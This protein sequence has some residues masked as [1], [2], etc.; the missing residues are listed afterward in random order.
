MSSPSNS[1]IFYVRDTSVSGTWILFAIAVG[2]I[3][4]SLFV[5]EIMRRRDAMKRIFYPR[6]KA[7]A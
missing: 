3:G 7:L 4:T 6:M 2:V 1:T 5:Y